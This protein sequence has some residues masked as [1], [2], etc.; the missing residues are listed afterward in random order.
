LLFIDMDFFVLHVFNT[1]MVWLLWVG[2]A[3]G[4]IALLFLSIFQRVSL[5]AAHSQLRQRMS[6][7]FLRIVFPLVW[8]SFTA[9]CPHPASMS[10]PRLLRTVALTPWFNNSRKNLSRRLSRAR[11]KVTPPTL[12]Y[13]MMLTLEGIQLTIL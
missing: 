13:M 5:W 8:P 2:K 10:S 6:A 3:K 4:D 12:L 1:K 9:S 7:Y 11:C